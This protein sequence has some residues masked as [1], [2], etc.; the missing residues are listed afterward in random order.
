LS[1]RLKLKNSRL[2]KTPDQQLTPKKDQHKTAK[3][4]R[5]KQQEGKVHH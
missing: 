2:N 4:K 5:I 3:E 1:V